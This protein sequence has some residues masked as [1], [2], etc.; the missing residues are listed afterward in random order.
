MTYDPCVE[1]MELAEAKRT[2]KKVVIEPTPEAARWLELKFGMHFFNMARWHWVELYEHIKSIQPECLVGVNGTSGRSGEVI[3]WPSD[4]RIGEK[5]T[6]AENDRKIWYC[7]G[8]G[9]W[10]PYEAC[11][12][13]SMG[14]GK[15]MF[16]HGK[17]F[18]HEDDKESR[19]ADQII[20]MKNVTNDRGGN[21]VLN[22][23]PD[24]RGLL[25][26]VDVA[27]LREIGDHLK[28]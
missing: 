27:R 5:K 12:V 11:H 9:S 3:M 25:R 19:P 23:A 20:E 21:F 26:D 17:W 1:E 7:G 16:P 6:P 28:S 13:L 2:K 22:A 10:L 24:N 4:F 18:W 15:G 14:T 8:L